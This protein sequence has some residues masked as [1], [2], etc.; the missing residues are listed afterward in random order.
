M[1]GIVALATG[2]YASHEVGERGACG[3]GDEVTGWPCGAEPT[4]LVPPLGVCALD[5]GSLVA[6]GDATRGASCTPTEA[7]DRFELAPIECA[8][9][10][11]RRRFV[12]RCGDAASSASF[13]AWPA[14]PPFVLHRYD[15]SRARCAVSDRS[16][17]EPAEPWRPFVEATELCDDPYA[18]C[19]T[20][21]V[22][23]LRQP[24]GDACGGGAF[25]T[26]RCAASIEAGRIVLRAEGARAL[27]SVC[28]GAEGDRVA[29]CVVPPLA[30]GRHEVVDG[31][32][33]RLGAIEVPAVQPVGD[34][35]RT[36]API[37]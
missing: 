15:L 27:A 20:P 25:H 4:T 19:G 28:V 23:E 33:R 21:L 14:R 10:T 29:T 34:L 12:S 16:I 37:P 9:D 5:D 36:C 13:R 7:P 2:C 35:E 8:P 18:W 3:P 17:R 22:L 11:P 24:H 30:A 6:F 31:E 32:G 26:H 1:L